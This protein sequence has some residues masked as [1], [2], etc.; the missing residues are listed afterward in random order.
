MKRIY[1]NSFLVILPNTTVLDPIL[2][3]CIHELNFVRTIFGLKVFL[4]SD[5]YP[6]MCF[7]VMFNTAL[8]AEFLHDMKDFGFDVTLNS[9]DWR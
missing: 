2:Y 9:F 8:H 7:K 4:S 3:I 1:L 5:D 6:S